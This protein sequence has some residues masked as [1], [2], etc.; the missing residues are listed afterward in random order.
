MERED[1]STGAV[2]GSVKKWVG[3]REVEGQKF[4]VPAEPGQRIGNWKAVTEPSPETH[5]VGTHP[6]VYSHPHQG[7]PWLPACKD[8]PA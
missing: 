2:S 8:R 4:Q 5:L 7:Q 3:R 1:V 6:S